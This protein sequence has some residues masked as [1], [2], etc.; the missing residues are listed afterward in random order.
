[1]SDSAQGRRVIR[2]YRFPNG[3]RAC[4]RADRTT[5]GFNALG[6]T[7]QE[8]RDALAVAIWQARGKGRAPMSG[9]R[10]PLRI[11]EAQCPLHE[12]GRA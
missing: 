6:R 4:I 3:A 7:A 2:R 1:M 9:K 5:Y 10:W 8:A 12:G 11:I